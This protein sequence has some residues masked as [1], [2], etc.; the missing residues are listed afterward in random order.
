MEQTSEIPDPANYGIGPPLPDVLTLADLL[1]DQSVVQAK[2]Q[3]DK[4][5]LESIWTQPASAL[6]PKLVEWVLKGRPS[7]FPIYIVDI[8]PPARCSDGEVRDLADYI[9]FCS[10][11]TIAEHVSLLQEKLPD[12]QLSF[13]NINGSIA[14]VTLMV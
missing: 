3:A 13:A 4:E 1:S 11:K 8:R 7:A 9:M 10:G 12:I 6:R 5:L 2:E 14:V